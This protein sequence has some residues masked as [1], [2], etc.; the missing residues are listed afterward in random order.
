METE[1]NF[2]L[3]R[4]IKSTGFTFVEVTVSLSFLEPYVSYNEN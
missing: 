2:N 3:Q 4:Y 1:F